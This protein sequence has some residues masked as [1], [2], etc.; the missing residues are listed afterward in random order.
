MCV[1]GLRG[2]G[3]VAGG[4]PDLHVVL[5]DSS[6]RPEGDFFSDC[7]TFL[8]YVLQPSILQTF[9]FSNLNYSDY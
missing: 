4:L 3:L 1:L 8:S 6:S 5:F 7:C 2:K 9:E